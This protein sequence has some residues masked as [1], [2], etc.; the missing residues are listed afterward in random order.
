MP[1]EYT[2]QWFDVFLETMPINMTAFEVDAV[3]ARLE[4]PGFRR[5]LDICCGPARHAAP[6]VQRG[7]EVTGIDR[8]ATAVAMASER[9]P[10][11]R[12]IELDQRDLARLDETFDAAV[13]LWQSFGYFDSPTNDEVLAAIAS[14]LRPGGRLMLDLFHRGYFDQNQGRVSPTR[15]PR[16][17]AITNTMHGTR[18]RSDIEYADGSRETMDFELFTPDEIQGRAS[19]FGLDLIEV[20]CWWDSRRPPSA[21]EQRFQAMFERI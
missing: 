8:D 14:V 6:L 1:N 4:L 10:G 21:E 7:Y 17:V 9:C 15:D 12:F 11:G 16:C 18:L 19:P 5:I 3:A 20:C 2:P 13:V